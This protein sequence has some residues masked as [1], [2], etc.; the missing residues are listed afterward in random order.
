MIGCAIELLDRD[1]REGPGA[2]NFL[3]PNPIRLR[4]FFMNP[5]KGKVEI[6]ISI[7]LSPQLRAPQPHPTAAAHVGF[8]KRDFYLKK[9]KEIAL[10]QGKKNEM[11][12]R[13]GT[14]LINP[15]QTRSW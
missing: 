10:H 3:S 14:N 6:S 12:F 9:K 7:E 15:K 1:K 8:Y 5:H 13:K 11:Y 2:A 4:V